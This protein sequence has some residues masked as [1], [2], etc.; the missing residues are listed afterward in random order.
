MRNTAQAGA[1]NRAVRRVLLGLLAANILVVVIKLAVGIATGSLAVFGDTIHS[2]VDALNNILA[3]LVMRVAAKEPDDDHPY[4]H[5]KFESLGALLVVVF[6]S[7]SVFELLKGAVVRL[8]GQV[9][10]VPPAPLDII[11]LVVTLAINIW[12]AWYESR[13][14]KRLKSE[15]LL[16]D[17][18]HTRVDVF[19]TIGV[20]ASLFLAGAGY[21]WADP[22]LAIIV[23]VL[24]AHIG[25]QII[26]RATPAL[27]DQVALDQ[28][29]I[30]GTAEKV[31]GVVR[32]YGIRSRTAA[33]VRFAEL[34]IAVD[35]QVNVTAAH[36]IA[37]A[38]EAT[39]RTELGIQ[40]IVVHVEPC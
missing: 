37:D 15:I 9:T 31:V 16:A 25:L 13:Q 17:A 6:L 36:E 39:I 7:V 26:R 24:I 10:L 1:R 11:L 38:V 3:L 40:E 27:V 2:S 4:G 19:I 35:G 14:G 12:V 18:A 33:S 22:V 21:H 8:S 23:A 34:T 28:D 32:A 5:E 29:K 20:I 30:R